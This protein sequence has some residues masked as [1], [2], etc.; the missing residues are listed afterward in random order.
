MAGQLSAKRHAQAVFEIALEKD[1]L[2]RWRADL[3]QIAALGDDKRA[4]AWLESAKV[5][6]DHKSRYLKEALGDVSPLAR[7]LV[8]L[9]LAR[10]S[11]GAAGAIAAAY[12]ERLR[13]HR[14]ITAA[15]VT[16]AVKLDE[17]TQRRLREELAA[18]TGR[19]IELETRIDPAVVGGFVAKVGDRLLDGSTRHR[20]EAL[21]QDLAYRR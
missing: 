9:L 14:G 11:L 6:A 17:A 15:T 10:R 12:E 18:I 4:V 3:K 21:R 16:S 8:E 19:E 2:E 7:N 20:L 5:S 13:E 1:E